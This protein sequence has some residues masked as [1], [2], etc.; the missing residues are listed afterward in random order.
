M[1]RSRRELFIDMV[2]DRDI[3]S[4][5]Q[6]MLFPF[7]NFISKTSMGPPKTGDSFYCVPALDRESIASQCMDIHRNARISKW[8][9]IKAWIIEY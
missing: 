6:I 9:S 4:F 3:S 1:K 7:L 2:V 8:I 5:N